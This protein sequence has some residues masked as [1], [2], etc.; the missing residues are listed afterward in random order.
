MGEIMRFERLFPV[1]LTVAVVVP[2]VVA[3]QGNV[4]DSLQFD[5]AWITIGAIPTNDPPSWPADSYTG[6]EI[7]GRDLRHLPRVG[8]RVRTRGAYVMV[9]V[10]FAISGEAKR[11]QSPADRVPQPPTDYLERDLPPG[12]DIVV[13]DVQID[14]SPTGGL[15]TVWIRISPD[16]R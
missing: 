10:D 9:I 11:L 1:L 7:D 15:R 5:T 2:P 13:K 12:S 6:L 4:W 8:D 14:S 3:A 16:T